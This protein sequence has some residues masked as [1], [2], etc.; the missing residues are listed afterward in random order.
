MRACVSSAHITICCALKNTRCSKIVQRCG[1]T[2]PKCGKDAHLGAR[3]TGLITG[4]FV[5]VHVLPVVPMS[6]HEAVHAVNMCAILTEQIIAI[7]KGR[8]F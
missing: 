6:E 8:K 3:V 1:Q 5:V 7:W 4:S 2:T